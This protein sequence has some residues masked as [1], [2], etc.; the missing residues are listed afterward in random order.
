MVQSSCS[1]CLDKGSS[2]C[3][4]R[5][6]ASFSLSLWVCPFLLSSPFKA[7]WMDNNALPDNWIHGSCDGDVVSSRLV[8]HH[9]KSRSRVLHR[10]IPNGSSVFRL[11]RPES[12]QRETARLSAGRRPVSLSNNLFFFLNDPLDVSID[13]N[14]WDFCGIETFV[15]LSVNPAGRAVWRQFR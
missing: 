3:P 2:S 1:R 7:G 9:T 4:N 11:F 15:L 13:V 6:N 8:L 14:S 10:W 5:R 12:V